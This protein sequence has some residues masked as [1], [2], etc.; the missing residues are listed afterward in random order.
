MKDRN[1]GKGGSEQQKGQKA[2]QAEEKKAPPYTKD[3]AWQEQVRGEVWT[4]LGL[5]NLDHGPQGSGSI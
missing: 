4:D 5:R 2:P 3:K 1:P